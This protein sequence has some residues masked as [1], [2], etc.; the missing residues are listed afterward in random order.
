M[1]RAILKEEREI[2]RYGRTKEEA[3]DELLGLQEDVFAFSCIVGSVDE[4]YN[5]IVDDIGLLTYLDDIAKEKVK[6]DCF[7]MPNTLYHKQERVKELLYDKGKLPFEMEYKG[8]EDPEEMYHDT[9]RLFFESDGTLEEWYESVLKD[10]ELL[11]IY[12]T[13]FNDCPEL[14]ALIENRAA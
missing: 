9:K 11:K 7:F 10:P 5:V 12:I 14:D 2:A 4:L 6:K 13:H 1:N 3:K 8:S